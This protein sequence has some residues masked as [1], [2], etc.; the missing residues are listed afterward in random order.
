MTLFLAVLL[1]IGHLRAIDAA[2]DQAIQE[3]RLPGG[4]LHLEHDGAVYEKAY[5]NRALV[6]RVEKMTRDTI[7]DAASITKVAATTPA[8]AVA[9][10]TAA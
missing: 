8:S 9:L 1:A 2:I 10:Q 5:G 4:V 3:K 6:P 7:F